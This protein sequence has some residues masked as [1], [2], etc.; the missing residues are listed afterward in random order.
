MALTKEEFIANND[1]FAIAEHHL[2]RALEALLDIGRHIIAKK[3]LGRPED[4]KS[5]ITLLGK[6]GVI[7]MEFMLKIQGMAG[8]RNRLVHG[9]ADVTAEEIYDLLKE[10]LADFAE[11]VYYIL[12]YLNKEN[13]VQKGGTG[14]DTKNCSRTPSPGN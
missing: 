13:V 7:P 10:R 8:Y 6:N 14:D 4:Y 2:R 12:D 1:N 3:G 9:Y 5:I 11:F